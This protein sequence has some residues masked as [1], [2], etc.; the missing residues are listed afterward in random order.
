MKILPAID[1]YRGKVVRLY[2]GDYN[3]M[4]VY[5]KDP[6]AVAHTIAEAGADSLH[7]VDLEGARDGGTPNIGLVKRL[8]AESGMK[9]EIGG[10]VRS[11]EVVVDY[12]QAGVL[13]VI[14]GTAA[15]TRPDFAREMAQRY[16]AAIA[17][18]VDVWNGQVAIK[19]WTETT[20]LEMMPFCRQL[21][22]DGIQ[23]LICTDIAK[24]GVM[25]GVNREMYTKLQ[26]ELGMK[27][28]ASGGVSNLDDIRAL[29]DRGLYGVI[30][31]KSLYSGAVDLR[32]ALEVAEGKR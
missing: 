5:S 10:G 12:L 17:V 21:E 4:T 11:E 28:I 26:E 13:R 32:E 1:L 7:V 31:G 14:L 27:V 23:T 15:V 8:A 22:Q 6:L 3:Q 18:G 29:R 16:G 2:Q 20:A 30:L 19:G 24:D 9:I 25:A